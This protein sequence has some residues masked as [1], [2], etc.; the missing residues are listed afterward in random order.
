MKITEILAESITFHPATLTKDSKGREVIGFADQDEEKVECY[1]CD[2]TGKDPYEEDGSPCKRCN[3]KGWEMEMVGRGPEMNVSNS[4]GYAIQQMLGMEPDEY[5]FVDNKDLPKLMAKL[6]K[7]ANK[8]SNGWTKDQSTERGDMGKQG[9][10]GNV[11]SI[12]RTG[13]TVMDMGRSQGQVDSYIER[14]MKIV[15]YAQKNGHGIS[16]G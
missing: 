16:W 8:D 5:G 2:G 15:Q 9:S 6:M 12:G 13:P 3:G 7:L 1:I 11:T 4:N 10:D 14:L